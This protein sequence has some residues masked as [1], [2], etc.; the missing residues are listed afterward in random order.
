MK[1]VLS[2]ILITVIML[3]I[4]MVPAFLVVKSVGVEL[5]LL[6][7]QY[8][9]GQPII[10][11]PGPSTAEWPKVLQPVVEIWRLASENLQEAA[12]Q[13]SEQ[14]QSVGGV[15]LKALAGIGIGVLQFLASIL[16]AGVLL[17]FAAPA[18]EG[19]KKVFNRLAGKEGENYIKLTVNTVRSVVKGI[20]GVAFIQA[21]MAALGFF[22]A[23]VPYAGLWSVIV[24][25]L[26]VVQVGA[27]PVVIPVVIYMFS[28][29]DTLTATLL[30]I[31]MGIVLVADN[32]L[33][34]LLLGRGSTVP[35][36]VVFLGAIGGFISSG[37]LGLFLGAVVLSIG[38][39]LFIGWLNGNDMEKVAKE[40]A[41]VK[42]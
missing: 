5:N 32:V 38:Y 1:R 34:P 19:L 12:S 39:E 21:A 26:A 2:S 28:V 14:I 23:G 8:Q 4:L 42:K 6:R 24:L 9:A 29:A 40:T 11:M 16:V 36:L 18:H 13:Y 3:S 17:A 25:I 7:E 10:P 37:F 31:W 22:M 33:K 30:A 41:P 27:G 15:I 20:L 35:M